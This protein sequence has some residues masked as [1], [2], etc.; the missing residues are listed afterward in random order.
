MPPE[1]GNFSATG[2]LLADA[3]RSAALTVLLALDDGAMATLHAE[4]ARLD[5]PLRKELAAETGR[6][7]AEVRHSVELRYRGQT[8]SVEVA[9]DGVASAAELKTRFEAAYRA[10]YGHAEPAN[11]AELVGLRSTAATP[12]PGPDLERLNPAAKSGEGKVSERTRKV[13]FGGGRGLLDTRVLSRRALPVGFSAPG[14]CVIEE[15]GSTTL[16]GPDDR[17][18][19]GRLGEVR[20]HIGGA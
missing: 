12:L 10:R 19:I 5:A 20:I 11:T 1:P 15:Y 14:P 3:R 6:A 13:Y 7:D 18:A 16:V 2:M 17:C 8:H 9:F 4:F